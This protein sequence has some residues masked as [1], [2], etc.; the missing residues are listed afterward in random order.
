MSPNYRVETSG[1]SGTS[2]IVSNYPVINLVF[3]F[4]YH[5]DYHNYV[6]GFAIGVWKI[7]K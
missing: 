4:R 5:N 2:M 7:K 6:D 1:G 3:G